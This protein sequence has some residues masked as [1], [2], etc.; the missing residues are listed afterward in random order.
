MLRFRMRH[1]VLVAVI[2]SLALGYG[3][4]SWG[5]TTP[6]AGSLLREYEKTVPPVAPPPSETPAPSDQGE[7]GAH[8]QEMRV[9]V[10]G[11]SIESHQFPE[12][13]LQKVVSDYI[14]KEHTLVELQKAARKISAYYLDHGFMARAYLPPQTIKDGIVKIIVQEGKL[15]QIRIDPSSRSRFDTEEAKEFI[16]NRITEGQILCPDELHEGVAVLNEVPG[17]VATATLK[18]GA[19]KGETDAVVKISNAP[20][21]SSSFQVDNEGIRSVGS[22][23]GIA[24]AFVND[25]LGLGEQFS[26]TVLKSSGSDYSRLGITLPAGTSGLRYGVNASMMHYGVDLD[27]NSADQEGYAYTFGGTMSY[28]VMRHADMSI[29]TDIA[30]DHKRL[31]NSV[32]DLN[33]SDKQVDVGG[34]HANVIATD[35]MFAGAVN[36]FDTS[37]ALG[38]IDLSGDRGNYT[39]DQSSARTNGFYSR[40]NVSASRL[41]S[42]NKIHQLFLSVSGQYA[43]QNL[44]S[45]EQFSLGGPEGVRAYPTDEALG[46]IGVLNRVE[47]RHNVHESVQLFDFYDAGWVR[48]HSHAWDGA[49]TG[50]P[51]DYWLQDC[52]VGVRWNPIERGQ[53]SATVAHTLGTNDGQVNGYNSDGYNNHLRLLLQASY[54]F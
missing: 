45:S 38:N 44:D 43:P 46:D 40:M 24:S 30:F 11:F 25:A 37:I 20:I 50:Q 3:G 42:F 1:S 21:V 2:W 17:V 39:Q 31:V 26:A 6:D 8:K 36:R 49:T 9:L 12:A 15:G 33:S 29:S 7:E 47:L 53:L 14:G 35:G 4:P 23:R 48:Q 18:P 51:N 13:E 5:Q 54:A 32:Q 52:G 27:F 41:Q 19:N 16:E 22:T 10:K 28:P 34:A